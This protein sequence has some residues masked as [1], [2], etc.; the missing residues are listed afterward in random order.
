[1]EG[2]DGRFPGDLDQI[3]SLPGVG[4]YTAAAVGSIAFGLPSPVVDGNVVRVLTRLDG[5]RGRPDRQPL[6]G[7]LVRRAEELLHPARP[8]DSNQAL[9]EL[10]ATVCKPRDP[11]CS[12]CPWRQ[13]CVAR[14]DGLTAL[15]PETAPRPETVTVWRAAAWVVRRD[16]RILLRRAPKGAHNAGLWELPWV[17]FARG[18]PGDSP[19]LP[20]VPAS[21]MLE[22]ALHSLGLELGLAREDMRLLGEIKHNITRH[23]IRV[24]LLSGLKAAAAGGAW[25]R[26]PTVGWFDDVQAGERGLTGAARKL[27]ALA[28]VP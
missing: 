26:G 11:S 14:R 12:L 13:P 6:R 22:D 9:M 3:R 21:E 28:T 23:R 16:G 24:F 15:L 4:P 20:R 17:E 2:F 27:L 10:G 5:K 8:G 7:A 25:D 1:M 18:G 19:A